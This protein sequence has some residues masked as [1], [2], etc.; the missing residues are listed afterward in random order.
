M[1][2]DELMFGPATDPGQIVSALGQRYDVRIEPLTS[3][4][5]ICLDT[6]DWRLFRAG[7]T[8][9]DV[10][11][12]RRGQLVLTP[13]DGDTLT[14]PAPA[15]GWPR[16][17]ES[18]PASPVRD[19]IA[20]P[21]GVR[22][23]LPLVEVE[24]RSLGLRLLDDEGKTRVR[25]QIDQQRLTGE[26]PAPLPLR[27]AVAPLRGYE[28]DGRRCAELLAES[29][30]PLPDAGNAAAV[31]F[32]AAGLVPGQPVAPP[33]RLDPQAPAVESVAVVLR[34]WID[35]VDVARPGALADTDIEYLHDLRTAVR[36]TRSVL[37]LSADLLAETYTTHFAGEFAWVGELTTPLRDLDVSLLELD[38]R[39]DVDL[40]GLLDDLEPVRRYL[41]NERR[42]ALRA[43][44]AGLESP[45]GTHLSA[46]WRAAL[47]QLASPQLP[48]GPTTVE[49]AAAQARAAYKRIVKAAAPVG[50]DTVP[51]HLHGLRRRCKR[52][53]YLLDGYASV[54]AP[55]PQREVLSALKAL[56]DCLGD[57]QDVDVQRRSLAE[58]A[59]TLAK[60]GAPVPTLLAIG[61]LRER[62]TRRDDAARRTLARRLQRFTGAAT[63]ERV[64]ELG[65]S[66]A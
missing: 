42:R 16:R 2:P 36:A 33:L 38:G 30:A 9:R 44:R 43:F 5:W 62:M 8:L 15:V 13:T 56:Q 1:E 11:D 31:A 54:F 39:G 57:I 28:R 61:A 14:A 37:R 21:V 4:R 3:G 18:L 32:A 35:I 19:R 17:V 66:P 41:A 45:R 27:V 22:A 29:A 7:L 20:A 24:V 65:A 47:D 26:R 25:V 64:E 12:G 48:G 51:D 53:R 58:I 23:L 59:A 6:A 34:R 55:E 50:R 49:V 63:R 52:M 46:D 40:T 10:R 60:R